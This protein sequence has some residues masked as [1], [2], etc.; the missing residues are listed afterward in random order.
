MERKKLRS[1][2]LLDLCAFAATLYDGESRKELLKE[3]ELAYNIA[4]E[5]NLPELHA[6]E[7]FIERL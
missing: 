1:F 5:Y 2:L 6:Y 4:K 7:E 3:Y